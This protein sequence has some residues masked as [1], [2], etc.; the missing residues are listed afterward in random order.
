MAAGVSNDLRKKASK[1]GSLKCYFFPDIR[2]VK[3]RCSM[4]GGIEKHEST[5][6]DNVDVTGS[7]FRLTDA[8]FLKAS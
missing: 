2:A 1:S 7:I 5:K 4:I 8:G 3:D 6:I